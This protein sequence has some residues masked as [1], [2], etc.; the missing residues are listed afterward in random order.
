MARPSPS[1]AHLERIAAR[2]VYP[3]ERLATPDS[4]ARCQVRNLS[5]TRFAVLINS[6]P[7]ARLHQPP[8][9]QDSCAMALGWQRRFRA[10]VDMLARIQ[11]ELSAPHLPTASAIRPRAQRVRA[12]CS[13]AHRPPPPVW[14]VKKKAIPPLQVA[15][16]APSAR[17]VRLVS[18]VHLSRS[19]RPQW[20]RFIANQHPS[21]RAILSNAKRMQVK[22]TKA[23]CDLHSWAAAQHFSSRA[24]SSLPP[25]KNS[26]VLGEQLIAPVAT[27]QIPPSAGCQ[28]TL[29][30]CVRTMFL[31][32]V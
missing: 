22:T 18:W 32:A 20:T 2:Q 25:L 24:L 11:L 30:S 15:L 10:L 9:R 27:K 21:C 23:S 26:S 17:P 28:W 5:P 31:T 6:V 8:A 7:R 19:A 3:L 29:F 4:I 13:A 14:F 1:T 16:L 12:A